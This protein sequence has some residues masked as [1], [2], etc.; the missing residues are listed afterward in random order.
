MTRHRAVALLMTVAMA[1]AANWACD[2]GSCAAV[3][4]GGFQLD[5]RVDAT[6]ADPITLDIQAEN[7]RTTWTCDPG[8]NRCTRES[9]V[10]G[11]RDFDVELTMAART[12]PF[13]GVP[14]D[15]AACIRM[16]IRG[17]SDDADDAGTY[18]PESV[19]VAIIGNDGEEWSQD[20]SPDYD[21][22]DGYGG[23][24]CGYCDSLESFDERATVQ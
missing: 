5:L 7:S 19:V 8:N 2:L 11:D 12:L 23:E 1:G 16:Q 3:C 18:G 14:C 10:T 15:A 13:V 24:D 6:D 4:A 20:Y 21:R 17:E 9:V 22:T